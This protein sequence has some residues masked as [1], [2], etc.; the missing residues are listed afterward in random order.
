MAIDWNQSSSA[1]NRV[2]GAVKR[3]DDPQ[4]SIPAATEVGSADRR[5]CAAR[6][7]SA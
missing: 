3:H 6:Q 7:K 4:L 2:E 5:Q 1:G